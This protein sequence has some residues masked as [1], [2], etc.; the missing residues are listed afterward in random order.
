V[1]FQNTRRGIGGDGAFLRSYRAYSDADESPESRYRLS[2]QQ[3]TE[4]AWSKE[5]RT[6]S[7]TDSNTGMSGRLV[8]GHARMEVAWYFQGKARTAVLDARDGPWICIALDTGPTKCLSFVVD[9]TRPECDYVVKTR[10][11][12]K[13]ACLRKVA[14][15]EN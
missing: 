13:S 7:L 4:L 10:K 2:A 3:L 6:F 9:A 8:L 5:T 11:D 12:G 14:D 1:W 15:G